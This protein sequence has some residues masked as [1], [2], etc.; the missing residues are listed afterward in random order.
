MVKKLSIYFSTKLTSLLNWQRNNPISTYC[1]IYNIK[2]GFRRLKHSLNH[3]VRVVSNNKKEGYPKQKCVSGGCVKRKI[4]DFPGG[5]P[6]I[7]EAY[8]S[9]LIYENN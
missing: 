7:K 2:Q 9:S 5:G 1:P 8:Q 6:I 4:M 3:N